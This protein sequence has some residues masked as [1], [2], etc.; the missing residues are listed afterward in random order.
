LA[1]VNSFQ[2][3]SKII[4][5]IKQSP[6]NKNTNYVA[7]SS[8]D[9]TVKIWNVSSSFN[10]TLIRANSNLLEQ[11]S[12]YVSDLEWLDNDTLASSGWY[13]KSIKIWSLKTGQTKRTINTNTNVGS[14]KLFKNK[15]HLAA[16]LYEGGINIYNINDGSLVSSLKLDS[17]HTDYLVQLS[18]DLL[19]CSSGL[20]ILIWNLTSAT[21]KFT[22]T[23]HT[24]NVNGLKQITPRI[25]TSV[26]LDQTIKL[27]NIKSGKLIRT[28]T[29]HT[30]TIYA[31]V[32]LINPQTLVSS[33]VVGE[34][35]LWNWP[36]GK[37]LNT[38]QTDSY[39]Y[40]LAVIDMSK[41]QSVKNS[42]LL[43]PDT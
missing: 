35:K 34:I 24:D 14:L 37:C 7:T 32:E 31:P 36:T 39:H 29:G 40:A 15:I 9:E 38:K 12:S 16:G 22:L 21:C 27:W 5:I 1:L 41:H 42:C 10:W 26:S 3:H 17:T 6:F 23:G 43:F 18:N 28:L 11:Q 30:N 4:N 19:A 25:L 33:T 13:E 2:A 20:S 8:D